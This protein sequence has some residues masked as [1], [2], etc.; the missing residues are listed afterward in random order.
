M[1]GSESIGDVAG[2]SGSASGYAGIGAKIDLDAGY[3]DGQLSFN[4]GLG[5]ALGL[6]Y[7]FDFGFSVNV[8]AIADGVKDGAEWV[9]NELEAGAGAVVSGVG[10]AVGGVVDGIG[11]AISSIF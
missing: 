9:G 5:A 8:G 7:S 6:G 11:D 2:V 10:D 3:K 1:K 4:F